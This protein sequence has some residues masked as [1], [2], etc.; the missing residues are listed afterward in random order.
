[1]R[2]ERLK[3]RVGK[4]RVREGLSEREWLIDWREKE[5]AG[6][7][8]CR[9]GLERESEAEAKKTTFLRLS[10]KLFILHSSSVLYFCSEG[11]QKWG[12]LFQSALTI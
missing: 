3:F 12:W 6:V 4:L 10:H 8:F 2:R 7:F 5:S 1:M 9:C 11:F